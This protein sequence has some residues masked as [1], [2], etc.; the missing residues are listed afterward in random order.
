M[1][2]ITCCGVNCSEIHGTWFGT[3]DLSE[4][5]KKVQYATF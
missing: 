4:A 3:A 2:E 5:H 1:S